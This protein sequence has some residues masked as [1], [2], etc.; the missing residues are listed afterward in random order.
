[1]KRMAL[2]FGL[3]SAALV[4]LI[5][6]SKYSLLTYQHAWEFATIGIAVTFIA[7]GVLLHIPGEP[8]P[9]IPLK[10]TQSIC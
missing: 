6:I 10:L 4:I 8:D 3:L 2:Q 1:M 7:L 9:P 5:Q